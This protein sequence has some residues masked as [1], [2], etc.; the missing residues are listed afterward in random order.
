MIIDDLA[1]LFPKTVGGKKIEWFLMFDSNRNFDVLMRVTTKECTSWEGNG[2]S[3][4]YYV[5]NKAADSSQALLSALNFAYSE[6]QRIVKTYS[7]NPISEVGW[8]ISERA[9]LAEYEN[10]LIEQRRC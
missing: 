8:I 6:I 2:E 3:V 7:Y 1:H 4:S 9:W 10:F 5:G